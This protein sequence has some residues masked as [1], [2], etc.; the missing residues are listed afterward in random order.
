MLAMQHLGWEAH[1]INYDD[2]KVTIGKLDGCSTDAEILAVSDQFCDELT[3][4]LQRVDSFV[5]AETKSLRS[6]FNSSDAASLRKVHSSV[7]A[8][9]GFVGTNVIAATKI[10][11]KHDKH[12]PPALSK[13][14]VIGNMIRGSDA[15]AQ[16][17]AFSAEVDAKSPKATKEASTEEENGLRSLPDWLLSGASGE[18]E[19]SETSGVESMHGQFR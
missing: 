6:D 15:L 18:Q 19:G 17:I 5:L 9:R 4:A 11:K 13:R 8:L 12:V 10:A 2:L 14:L 16:L 7:R 1:Y 3:K